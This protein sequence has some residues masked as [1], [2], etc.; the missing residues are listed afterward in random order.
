M[1]FSPR[2]L[3]T[4]ANFWCFEDKAGLEFLAR[5]ANGRY[6]LLLEAAAQIDA[7]GRRGIQLLVDFMKHEGH[8]DLESVEM[9]E[10]PD[11]DGA[12][13]LL[14]Y[15]FTAMADPHEFGYTYFDVAFSIHEPPLDRFWPIKFTV[16][17]H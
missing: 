11:N 17:F 6:E 3:V 1:D 2:N 10:A 5:G 8:F 14:R 4:K 12:S 13:L 7:L 9:L 16:G 15:S